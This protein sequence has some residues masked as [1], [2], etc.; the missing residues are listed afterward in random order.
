MSDPNDAL[1]GLTAP[2]LDQLSPDE[3]APAGRGPMKAPKLDATALVKEGRLAAGVAAQ[4]ITFPV[5]KARYLCL[6]ALSSQNDD[7]FTTLAELEALDAAGKAVSRQG[8]KILYVDSEETAAEAGQAEN[9]IDGQPDTFW[10]SLWSEGHP[11][12]PHALVID[13]GTEQEISGVRLLPRQDSPNG[14]IKDYR[15]YLSVRPFE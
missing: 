7:D 13:F 3:N 10:H 2:I 1:A 8:W 11:G 14:R 12:H 9:A 6:Q 15:L 4:D 5:T